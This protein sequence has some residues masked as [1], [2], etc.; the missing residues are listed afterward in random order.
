MD[1]FGLSS[2]SIVAL[3][4]GVIIGTVIMKVFGTAVTRTIITK[5]TTG[6][7]TIS[8]S[9]ILLIDLFLAGLFYYFRADLASY[10]KST[11]FLPIFVVLVLLYLGVLIW[12]F[13]IQTPDKIKKNSQW[14]SFL[15]LLYSGF[16]VF[17]FT[18]ELQITFGLSQSIL[19]IIMIG[20]FAGA[21]FIYY[22][23]INNKKKIRG[24][25]NG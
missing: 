13:K 2:G 14:F 16:I 20:S 19:F 23:R 4:I 17:M 3:A 22:K 24:S 10:F 15:S 7:E 11:A 18:N 8:W 21:F 25:I 12:Y 1:M 9:G 5:D 6:R